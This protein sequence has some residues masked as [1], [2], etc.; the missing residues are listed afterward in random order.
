M[1]SAWFRNMKIRTK[2]IVMV[3]ISTIA[4]LFVGV[5]GFLNI[6]ALK[7]ASATVINEGVVPMNTIHELESHHRAIE[8]YVLELN[9]TM[10]EQKNKELLASIYDTRESANQLL[11]ELQGMN[12]YPEEVEVLA[13]YNEVLIEYRD[14]QNYIIE[15]AKENRNTEAY[16][17]YSK[18]GTV[19]KEE[20]MGHLSQLKEH[21]TQSAQNIYQDNEAKA[22]QAVFIVLVCIVAAVVLLLACGIAIVRMITKPIRHMQEMMVQV[23]N[24]DLTVQADYQSKDEIGLV[25]RD[26]ND[27]ITGLNTLIASVKMSVAQISSS[28]E[29]L[30]KS[31]QQTV[32]ATNQVAAS[33][34]EIS[35]GAEAQQKGIEEVSSAMEEVTIG[36]QR[37]AESSST[38]SQFSTDTLN[39]AEKGQQV[40]AQTLDQF[41]TIYQT[42]EESAAVIHQLNK[43]SQE[44]GRIVEV[45]SE[46]TGQTNLLA[47]NA[48][49]EASRAGE[50]GRGFAVVADEVRKL[51][52]ESKNSADQISKIIALIQEE[53]ERAVQTIEGGKET[54]EKGKVFVQHTD[55]VFT[56]I[57]QMVQRVNE[58]VYE[59]SA[60]TEQM[61]ASTEEISASMKQLERIAR[62]ASQYA[63]A[64][65]ASS[66]EQLAEMEEVNTASQSL[67]EMATEL[68]K[69]ASL[70]KV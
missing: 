22:N 30:S 49:I 39:Q 66:Q 43:R 14:T 44:I 7:Q 59:I 31:A 13:K 64:S 4:L 67:Q 33:V 70:F 42:T 12:L 29:E 34:S 65:A 62:D 5:T 69:A 6:L 46:I 24:G 11:A 32:Q 35:T 21:L 9:L 27:T 18:T 60:S 8:G 47:L 51:A 25:M 58:Q 26:F 19:L 1:L 15:L 54:V 28:S 40:I 41:Q 45:I 3:A 2:I 52:E 23:K 38:L 16:S 53:T 61:S 37:I 48:A 50:H 57:S 36:V 68:Q 20:L 63:Q 55:E 17:I 10:N 56:T